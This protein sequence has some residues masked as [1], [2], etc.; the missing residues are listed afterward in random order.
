MKV[1]M[2]E[3]RRGAGGWH[4]GKQWRDYPPPGEVLDTTDV[5]GAQ[6]CA[7]GDAEPVTEERG[8]ETRPAPDTAEKRVPRSRTTRDPNALRA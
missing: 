7:Q 5:H 8:A 4:D 3:D 1:R 6:L 2:T